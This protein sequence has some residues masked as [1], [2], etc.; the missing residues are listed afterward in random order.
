MFG[1]GS[2]ELIVILIIAVLV[3]GPEKMVEYSAQLGRLIAKLRAETNDV[4]REFR[5]AFDLE[6]G[7][8]ANRKSGPSSPDFKVPDR[9]RAAGARPASSS[10]AA[11]AAAPSDGHT[12]LPD[13]APAAADAAPASEPETAADAEAQPA[14]PA[15][16]TWV[17][18]LA[19]Q[20]TPEQDDGGKELA[21]EAIDISVG[22][23]VYEDEEAPAVDLDG[24]TLVPSEEDE[25]A[26]VSEEENA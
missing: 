17:G 12:I 24:P 6:M 16:S 2:G 18:P 26:S 21:A 4:T 22:E 23:M 10:N 20:S 11:T 14:S 3:V 15:P 9:N 19:A 1:I 7:D 5:D 25:P 13:A 8:A